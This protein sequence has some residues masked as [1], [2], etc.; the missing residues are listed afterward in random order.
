M[1]SVNASK[2]KLQRMPFRGNM[3]N[4]HS[5]SLREVELLQC[6]LVRF[7]RKAANSFP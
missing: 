7:L 6:N 1:A 4:I 3:G 2:K 5:L